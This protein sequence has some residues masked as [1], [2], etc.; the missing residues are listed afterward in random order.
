MCSASALS[1]LLAFCHPLPDTACRP[2]VLFPIVGLQQGKNEA[3]LSLAQGKAP[4]DE[5]SHSKN[6]SIRFLVNSLQKKTLAGM[7]P[8]RSVGDRR[9]PLKKAALWREKRFF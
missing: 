5:S 1:H 4:A 6:A 9:G 3:K 8:P 7:V 2:A